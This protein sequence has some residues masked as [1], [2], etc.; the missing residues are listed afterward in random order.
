MSQCCYDYNISAIE[1]VWH[2]QHHLDDN[3]FRVITKDSSKY[4]IVPRLTYGSIAWEGNQVIPE[5]KK[6]ICAPVIDPSLTTRSVMLSMHPVPSHSL[7][8]EPLFSNWKVRVQGDLIEIS[9]VYVQFIK[10]MIYVVSFL[11]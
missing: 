2:H 7:K 5:N 3:D 10:I 8:V 11:L 9:P 4:K 6:D 1:W